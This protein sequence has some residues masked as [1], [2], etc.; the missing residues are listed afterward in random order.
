MLFVYLESYLLI[1]CKTKC[2]LFPYHHYLQQRPVEWRPHF[3]FPTL[4]YH[5]FVSFSFA[6]KQLK[7]NCHRTM[8]LSEEIKYFG[9]NT[10]VLKLSSLILKRASS[11]LFASHG[12]SCLLTS[13]RIGSFLTLTH[14][15]SNSSEVL[16]YTLSS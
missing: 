1:F 12:K 7:L 5:S 4:N 15:S 11:L 9:L 13:C 3:Q 6:L 14:S 8:S 2:I 10:F 16:S